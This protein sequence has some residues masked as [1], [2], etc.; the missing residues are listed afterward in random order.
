MSFEAQ[1]REW[2]EQY[3]VYSPLTDGAE[4]LRIDTTDFAAVDNEAVVARV[5]AALNLCAKC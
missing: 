4:L 3:P 5:R 2:C 1:A